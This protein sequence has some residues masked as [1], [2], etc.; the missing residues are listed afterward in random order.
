VSEDVRAAVVRG[1]LKCEGLLCEV[2]FR[3]RES[4][5]AGVVREGCYPREESGVCVCVRE[6]SFARAFVYV[7]ERV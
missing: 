2:S 5:P 7:R 4:T 6:Q 1:N 3:E